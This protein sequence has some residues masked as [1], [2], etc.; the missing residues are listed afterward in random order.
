MR[1]QHA[2]IFILFILFIT[3]GCGGD[4]N[5]ANGD[6]NK[7]NGDDGKNNEVL[8]KGQQ[9]RRKITD[10]K[11][12]KAYDKGY[13]TGYNFG[14]RMGLDYR[15]KTVHANRKIIKDTYLNQ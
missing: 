1:Q 12:R 8:L 3:V 4:N 9:E 10:D 14:K 6:P 7:N 13:T 15:S 11:L 5:N 2:V